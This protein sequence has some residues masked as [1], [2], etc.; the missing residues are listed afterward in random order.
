[1]EEAERKRVEIARHG[2]CTNAYHL[3]YIN[4]L[5]EALR[6]LPD[7]REYRHATNRKGPRAF[8][9]ADKPYRLVYDLCAGIEKAKAI[10]NSTSGEGVRV[11]E[12]LGDDRG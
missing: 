5:E 12:G 11:E 8:T 1:M 3:D 6:S 2:P 4:V 9:S 7:T 10:L